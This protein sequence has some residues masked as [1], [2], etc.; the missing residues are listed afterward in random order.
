MPLGSNSSGGRD[1]RQLDYYSPTGGQ[2]PVWSG[3]IGGNPTQYQNDL[4]A[5]KRAQGL[6]AQPAPQAAATGLRFNPRAYGPV[7]LTAGRAQ[8]LLPYNFQT[9]PFRY[10]SK[11]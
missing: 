3:G 11:V 1:V 6:L 9:Q 10:F 2:K 8:G 5:W 7:M 4:K